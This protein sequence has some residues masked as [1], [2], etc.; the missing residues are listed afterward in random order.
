MAKSSNATTGQIIRRIRTKEFAPVYSLFGGDAFLEDF[1]MNELSKTFLNKNGKR[2]HFSLDYDKPEYLF[3]ELSSISLFKEKKIII[4]REIKKLKS[5]KARNELYHYIK[6]PNYNIVL[7]L[8]SDMYDMKNTFLKKIS[9][10]SQL[11]DFRPPFENEMKQWISYVLQYKKI[12]VKAAILEEYIQLY[13]DSI[14][15]VIN[16][17][18]KASLLLG[19]VEINENN[20]EKLDGFDRI[21]Q[22]WHLQDSL[23]KKE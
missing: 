9:T 8:I 17:I 22:I 18:D 10:L 23:G 12:K 20:I 21:F 14:A 5:E 13:G 1:F 2:Q 7:I 19:D 16:E 4:V 15:H 3:L 6:N 11:M